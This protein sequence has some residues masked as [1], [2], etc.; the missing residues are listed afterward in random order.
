MNDYLL[1]DDLSGALDAAAAFHHSGRRVRI[2]WSTEAWRAAGPEEVVAFTTETRN[3]S[4]D[5]AAS[6][7]TAAMTFGTRRK[8]RLR[9][10]KIDSTLRGPV[11][12]EL[13][14]VL[15][16]LPEHNVLFLPANPAVGRTVRNEV[17]LVNGVPVAQTEF[18]RDPASPVRESSIRRLLAAVATERVIIADA[19][20]DADFEAAVRH[21]HQLGREWVGIGSGAL[22]RFVAPLCVTPAIASRPPSEPPAGPILM[23]CGSA[24]PQNH[25][26]AQTLARDSNV[27]VITVAAEKPDAAAR[28][29][30]RALDADGAAT[31]MLEST[32]T[33]RAAAL[34][35]I[36]VAAVNVIEAAGVS[37]LFVTGGETAFA[38]GQ[39]L[40]V[41]SLNFQT[42]IEPGLSVSAGIIH[43]RNAWFAIKPGGFG[44]AQTWVRAWRA[45]TTPERF[46]N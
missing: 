21:V 6:A 5:A 12:A 22:A 13:A 16:A 28:A 38:I 35:A 26:Q 44:D 25:A 9:Y 2:V 31:L 7:V 40:A 8:D 4:A 27:P 15:A 39:A 42:E 3:A 23:I 45:L 18:G 19:E 30:R 46:Q 14:A 20:T 37:R 1:A 29:A 41:D 24:H 11:A 33:E 17:L 43:G 34:H 32:R 10:K 36:T